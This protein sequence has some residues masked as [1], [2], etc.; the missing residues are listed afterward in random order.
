MKIQFFLAIMYLT[1]Y[2]WQSCPECPLMADRWCP[3]GQGELS[4]YNI[5]SLT[6]D[7]SIYCV[8]RV[9]L[10]SD[11]GPQYI[12]C[13]ESAWLWTTVYLVFGECL[14]VD[15]SIYCVCVSMCVHQKQQTQILKKSTCIVPT[16]KSISFSV[17]THV[18]WVK[19]HCPLPV[20]HF[21]PMYVMEWKYNSDGQ[22]VLQY[23]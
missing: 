6:V 15:H 10:K 7:H 18:Q 11:C 12:L 16:N 3:L 17:F 5:E 23:Q 8:W 22:Q 4:C 21:L 20:V 19:S 2:W 13:L 1:G 9:S 14:T